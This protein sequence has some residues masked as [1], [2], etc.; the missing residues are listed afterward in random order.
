MAAGTKIMEVLAPVLATAS[1]YS[2]K[3]GNVV[4]RLSTFSGRNASHNI[5]AVFFHF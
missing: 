1:F 5:G 3:N 2:I 4:H